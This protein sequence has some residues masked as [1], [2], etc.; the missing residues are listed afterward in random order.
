MYLTNS[1]ALDEFGFAAKRLFGEADVVVRGPRDGFPEALFVRL[2][3][4]PAVALASPVLELEAALP[5]RRDA[6]KVLG[7]DPFR[8]ASIQPALI[9]DLGPHLLELFAGDGIVLSAAAARELGLHRGDALEVVVGSRL[10]ALKVV[11]LLAPGTYAQPL[12]VMDIASAQNAFAQLGR[13]DR[14]DLR[15]RPGIDAGRF[16]AALADHLPAGVMALS[17]AVEQERAITLTRAYRLNLNMLALVALLTGAL[18][19]FSTQFCRCCGAAAP[20][21]CCAPWG[22]PAASCSVPWSAKVR[23]SV[24]SA[25]CS[26]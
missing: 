25:D 16:R 7:L 22:S 1:A 12:G 15:L 23:H 2:A 13:L 20:S 19:V 8:A 11:G 6:L 26:G 21:V 5:G 4:D 10:V 3:R 18:L 14:I 24:P 17:P 9:G